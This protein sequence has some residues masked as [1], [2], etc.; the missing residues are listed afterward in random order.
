MCPLSEDTQPVR[1]VPVSLATTAGLAQARPAGISSGQQKPGSPPT[2]DT[3]PVK[4]QP[5]RIAIEDEASSSEPEL[6][7]LIYA[8]RPSPPGRAFKWAWDVGGAVLSI[9]VLSYGG[10]L[11]F[12]N[13]DRFGPVPA[14]FKSVPWLVLGGGVLLTW[15]SVGIIYWARTQPGVR[16]HANGLYIEGRRKQSLPWE[17]IDGIAQGVTAPGRLRPGDMHYKVSLYPGKGRPLHLHGW[18]DG[19]R[20]M[21]YLPELVSRIKA[22]LYPGLQVELARMFREG[23]PL[24]FGP[25]RIDR[26]GLKVR[27]WRLFPGMFSVP[28]EHVKRIHVQS[29]YF[30]VESIDRRSPYRLPV[31]KIP[32]LEILLK[33]IDQG[34][35]Q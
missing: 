3:Q 7:R 4:T 8:Y 20:G 23:L 11:A 15:L 25:V 27:H 9:A 33:I 29:G 24:R 30:L 34:V 6:G 1:P 35:Q 13:Y 12:I 31:S 32:N 28:W 16:L 22:N 14:L 21:P 26:Q 10:Y 2:A 18:G 5:V 17:Q 19:K